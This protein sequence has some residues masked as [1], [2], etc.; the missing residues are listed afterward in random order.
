M[1]MKHLLLI[2]AITLTLP[3][4]AKTL[5]TLTNTDGKSIQAELISKD[6]D[7]LTFRRK[8]TYKDFTIIISTLSE[9]DQKFLET[10]IPTKSGISSGSS[11][12]SGDLN[13]KIYPRS[14]SEIKTEL[15]EILD[16]E[17]PKEAKEQAKAI[18][19]LNAYRYLSGVKPDV[20][21]SSQMNDEAEQA[22]KACLKNGALSHGIGSFTD[23][24]NLSS[25]GDMVQSVQAYMNDGGDN[26]REKRGHRKWCLNPGMGKSGFGSGGASY[27][28]MWSLDGSGSGNPR[29][30]WTY[31]GKGF[32]PK[33]Y[34]HGN[35]WSIYLEEQAPAKSE[36]TITMHKLRSRPDKLPG[37]TDNPEG[38]NITIKYIA[39]YG[40][41]I[42]FEPEGVDPNDRGIY[43]ITIKGGGVRERYITELY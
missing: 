18:N 28:A 16:R 1:T 30:S 38:K 29:E 35:G 11:S 33:E 24:C 23:K 40:N 27:S 8:G 10:W 43:Y 12:S 25:G 39:T 34:M 36:I 37:W 4:G 42:N 22:A 2:I 41:A 15:K 3:L 26:N 21:M 32:Y 13:S 6:G 31:P 20:K 9:E 14:K 19:L 7:K 17:T 5:R